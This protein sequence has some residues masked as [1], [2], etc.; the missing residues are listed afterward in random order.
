MY[1]Y[2]CIHTVDIN[3][4]YTY[5]MKHTTGIVTFQRYV[6]LIIL[7]ILNKNST[8]KSDCVFIKL[9]ISIVNTS[10]KRGGGMEHKRNIKSIKK[11]FLHIYP[12]KISF[13]KP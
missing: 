13:K 6:T 2:S 5:I 1:T 4:M 12:K 7:H 10:I 9:A 3:Y 11:C 8:R